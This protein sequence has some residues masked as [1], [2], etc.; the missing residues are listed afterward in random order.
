MK[1]LSKTFSNNG[2]NFDQL[3]T[4]EWRLI[5]CTLSLSV[6]TILTLITNN[7]HLRDSTDIQYI[8]FWITHVV[9]CTDECTGV[10]LG[11]CRKSRSE[12]GKAWEHTEAGSCWRHT[13][14][15]QCFY[16]CFL[17]SLP[18]WN[19]RIWITVCINK[20]THRQLWQVN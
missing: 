15:N 17:V 20:W 1:R 2:L 7:N 4:I 6:Y 13:S 19:E 16:M 8:M 18:H 12:V 9:L 11:H 14:W 5:K 3:K 10:S